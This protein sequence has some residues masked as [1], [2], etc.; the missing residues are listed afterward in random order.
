[1]ESNKLKTGPY[2][3]R[4]GI[5]A[6]SGT[7]DAPARE[8][9][10]VRSRGT[11]YPMLAIAAV[12]L[13]FFAGVPSA[14]PSSSASLERPASLQAFMRDVA[15]NELQA[16]KH[17][18]YSYEDRLKQQTPDGSQKSLQIQTQ[19]GLVSRLVDVDGK[20]PTE[21]QCRSNLDLLSR[22]AANPALQESRLRSQQS[23]MRRRETLFGE[24]PT[25]FLFHYEGTEKTTGLVRIRYS[26]NPAFHPRNRVDGILMG[27]QGT[28]WVDPSGKR[29]ARIQGTLNKSVTFGWGILA[30]LEQGGRFVMEQSRLP[31]GTWRESLLSVKFT[32][33]ILIF[34][35]LDVNI[36]RTFSSYKQ[37]ADGLTIEQAAD[38]LK[39]LP[40]H[41]TRP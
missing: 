29:I 26:P 24:M 21:K 8:R 1:M 12:S 20:P 3:L 27:L 25:A 15:W 19:Q 37:M 18:G 39:R 40:V 14:L 13:I 23:D 41:C 2:T 22:I 31:D 16:Q 34:K 32:G 5:S 4:G 10:H 28:M 17:P 6:P 11:L 38:M 35:R 30:R 9:G 7:A 36:T 33:T